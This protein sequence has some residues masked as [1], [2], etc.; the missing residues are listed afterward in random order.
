MEN[1]LGMIALEETSNGW[2]DRVIPSRVRAWPFWSALWFSAWQTAISA[3]IG[4]YIYDRIQEEIIKC[5]PPHNTPAFYPCP[6]LSFNCRNRLS[7][8]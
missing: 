5:G 4:N 8:L 6:Q 3:M 2:P 7:N 1:F